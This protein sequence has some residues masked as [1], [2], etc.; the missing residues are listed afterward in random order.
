MTPITVGSQGWRTVGYRLA[1]PVTPS[2]PLVDAGLVALG[3][4]LGSLTRWG[5][6]ELLPGTW[7]TLTV[8]LVGCLAIG[9][10]VGLVEDRRPRLRLLAGVGFLGGFT[11]FS[12]FLL[13]TSALSTGPGAAYAVATVVGCTLLAAL[14]LRAGRSA[15]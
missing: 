11:T 10:L 4:A 1:V 7:A 5:V 3:G 15:R 8:N 9:L 2:R 13:E 6:G 12:A 14:G